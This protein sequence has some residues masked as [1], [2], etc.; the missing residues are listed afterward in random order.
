MDNIRAFV[1]GSADRIVII[2]NVQSSIKRHFG[3][4]ANIS[5]SYIVLFDEVLLSTD[6][7]TM[8]IIPD[9][10]VDINKWVLKSI[11]DS[12]FI[13][14]PICCDVGVKSVNHESCCGF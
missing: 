2:Y 11:I 4:C 12:Q 10:K 8:S 6:Y 14:C 13:E 3:I 5:P 9:I 7:V 1:H